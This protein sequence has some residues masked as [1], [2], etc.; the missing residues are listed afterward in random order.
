MYEI[1]QRDRILAWTSLW[2]Y[3][4]ASIL[5]LD[6]EFYTPVSMTSLLLVF[7][8]ITSGSFS[9]LHWNNNVSGSWLHIA[10][11]TSGVLLACFIVYNL[12]EFGRI[13]TCSI[14][15]VGMF[16]FFILQRLEQNKRPVDWNRVTTLHLIFRYFGFWLAMEF[17]SPF[18]G[19]TGDFIIRIVLHSAYVLHIAW[20]QQTQIP[21]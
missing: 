1:K 9:L 6:P 12:V 5:M 10:D 7:L 18:S 16:T 14:L 4:P 19:H 3:V 15:A 11:F 13:L 21:T 8:L 20:L 17:V 2:I